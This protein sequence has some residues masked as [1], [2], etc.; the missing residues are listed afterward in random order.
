MDP[1]GSWRGPYLCLWPMKSEKNGT[2]G[3]KLRIFR[4]KNIKPLDEETKMCIM[5]EEKNVNFS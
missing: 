4:E 2:S 5:I 1:G 3:I